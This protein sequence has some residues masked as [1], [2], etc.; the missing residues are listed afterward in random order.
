MKI[1]CGGPPHPDIVTWAQQAESL[2]YD[3]YWSYDSPALYGDLWIALARIAEHTDRIGVGSAVAVP[4]LRH[5][6]VTASAI[7]TIE[8]L[9]PG[10]LA[11][12]FGTGY[13]ARKALGQKAWKWVL[14][15]EY[16]TQLRALLAGE[17][18]DVDGGAAQMLHL[19]GFIPPRP[20][21]VP[22]LL[23]PLGPKGMEV[24]T[25]VADGAMVP[26]GMPVPA[27]DWSAVFATGTVLDPDEDH[28]TPRVRE[29]AGPWF[30]ASYHAVWES[31]PEAVDGMP[32][33]AEWRKVIEERPERERHLLVHT[34]H[35][36]GVPDHEQP[37]LDAAGPAL[38]D[39]GWT[40]DAGA[41]RAKAQEAAA[42]GA[43]EIVYMPA[44]PDIPRELDAFMAAA[45]G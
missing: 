19:P 45:T 42:A 24:T 41:V 7:A 2:G 39:S 20:I 21:E 9:A 26:A 37:L 17:V 38:L 3:R 40:G 4:S 32:G 44:G 34:G 18:V 6:M 35:V 13:T 36:E 14:L 25:R 22:I 29:A 8:S 11:V 31:A 1:S 12:A 15:E 28:T 27:M 16:V 43:T 5:V 33:G 10:R 30:T 23:A